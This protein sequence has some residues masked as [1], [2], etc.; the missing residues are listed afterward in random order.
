MVTNTKRDVTLIPGDGIGPEITAAV[1]AVLDAVGAPFN[2]ITMQAGEKS[3]T[4]H[5][6]ALPPETVESMRRTGL[7]LK[8]PLGTPSGKGYRSATVQMREELDMFANV[9]P[10]KTLIPGRFKDVDIL[11]FRE[12]IQGLYAASE[13]WIALGGDPH[14]VA[15]AT[16]YNTKENM[17]RL[18][19]FAASEALKLGRKRV[20]L[21]HKSNI[22]KKLSGITLEALAVVSADPAYAGLVFNEMIVDAC[23]M[24]LVMYPESFDIIVTT[25]LFGDILSDLTAGIVGGLGLAPGANIGAD[26]ALFEAVHGTAPD[27]V[28]KGIANPSAL[29]MAAAMMLDHVG[30]SAEAERIRKAIV[31]T[32]TAGEGTGDVGGANNTADYVKALMTRL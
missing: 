27:I 5:G 30:L 28:G 7:A 2:W 19:R 32:I 18:I 4:E 24:K 1:V 21:V 15:T 25:N 9:R 31:E 17:V 12:N 23:A 11:L 22:L 16:A 3:F 10:A 29:L 8:G 6:V 14:A 26:C 13:T 20:T